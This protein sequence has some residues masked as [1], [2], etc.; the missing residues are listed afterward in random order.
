MAPGARM[1]RKFVKRS[2]FFSF[3]EGDSFAVFFWEGL[4]YSGFISRKNAIMRAPRPPALASAR[5][6]HVANVKASAKILFAKYAILKCQPFA[7]I[8]SREINPLYGINIKAETARTDHVS[9]GSPL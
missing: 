9:G 2:Q 1:T 3:T 6:V 5:S 4:P 7:K 8:F